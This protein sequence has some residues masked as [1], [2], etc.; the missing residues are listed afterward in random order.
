MAR[1][2]IASAHS[3]LVAGRWRRHTISAASIVTTR[4]PNRDNASARANGAQSSGHGT[5]GIVPSVASIASKCR[6]P[7]RRSLALSG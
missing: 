1:S 3:R 6:I 5:T 7:L 4:M 2:A